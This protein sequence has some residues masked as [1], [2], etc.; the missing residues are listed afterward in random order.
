MN[1]TIQGILGTA[2]ANLASISGIDYPS[3]TNV[4]TFD[5]ATGHKLIVG[6]SEYS[7][8]SFSVAFGSKI[9][10]T[11][12]TGKTLPVG[13]RYY[14]DLQSYLS[15][16]IPVAGLYVKNEFA[17]G[18]A[19][20]TYDDGAARG[21][22][23]IALSSS[24]TDDGWS[25][26]NIGLNIV[27]GDGGVGTRA[28]AAG[29]RL[30]QQFERDWDNGLGAL[31][32]GTVS[33]AV[34]GTI[35][36]GVGTLF[37]SEITVGGYYYFGGNS[38]LIASVESNTRMT[39]A[40]PHAVG[41]SGSAIRAKQGQNEWWVS[42]GDNRCFQINVL[43]DDPNFGYNTMLAPA[44]ITPN[45]ANTT[46]EYLADRRALTLDGSLQVNGVALLSG[47]GNN[48]TIVPLTGPATYFH[49]GTT[50]DHVFRS[51]STTAGSIILN[52]TAAAGGSVKICSSAGS[53]AFYGVTPVARQLLATGTIA[54]VDNVITAL[55]NIGILRQS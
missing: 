55:Q 37:T 14:L 32:T 20:T 28:E 43:T 48:L 49:Y 22:A 35:V 9:S 34:D 36:T 38:K 46:L 53:V 16:A 11:N 21:K 15:S 29:P 2:L 51:A 24:T 7:A 6:Q 5:G 39:L 18:P 50:G 4:V 52:D 19:V 47:V 12:K 25:A 33:V 13:S 8:P 26:L 1:Y 42:L 31:K 44:R 27:P 40:K 41:C 45:V 54:T 30:Q 3:G 23:R 10:F 17:G